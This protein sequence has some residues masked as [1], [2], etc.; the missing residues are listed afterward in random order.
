MIPAK[1]S[2]DRADSGI[3]PGLAYSVGTSRASA[4]VGRA[5]EMPPQLGKVLG[6]R[7]EPMIFFA[8][9]LR[10]LTPYADSSPSYGRLGSA[11]DFAYTLIAN[12]RIV[13]T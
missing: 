1:I 2:D 8:R 6:G 10:P 3:A 7:C 5:W 12:V 11:E 13:L 9:R 4:A